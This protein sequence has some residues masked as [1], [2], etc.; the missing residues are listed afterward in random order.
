M[1]TK[2]FSASTFSPNIK[3]EKLFKSRYEK[4]LSVSRE[5]YSTPRK[6]VEE[7]INKMLGD[8]E[9]AEKDWDNKKE[10]FKKKKEEDKKKAFQEKKKKEGK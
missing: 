8:I 7:K 10:Y 5:K 9:K 1:P 3:E 4:I 2:T 6:K